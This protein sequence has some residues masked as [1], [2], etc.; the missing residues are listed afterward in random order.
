MAAN[1]DM[2][3]ELTHSYE[4]LIEA[5]K[6]CQADAMGK[7]QVTSVGGANQNI[8]FGDQMKTAEKLV[9]IKRALAKMGAPGFKLPGGLIRGIDLGGRK[10]CNDLRLPCCKTTHTNECKEEKPKKKGKK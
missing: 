10:C 8:T 1:Q 7:G 4:E 2:C 9:H 5:L 6:C 3:L